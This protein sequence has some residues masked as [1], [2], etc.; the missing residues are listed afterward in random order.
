MSGITQGSM[1]V[2]VCYTYK[3]PGILS[4]HYVMVGGRYVVVDQHNEIYH[5]IFTTVSYIVTIE[6]Q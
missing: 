1:Q 3:V 2:S 4:L 6:I 5:Q